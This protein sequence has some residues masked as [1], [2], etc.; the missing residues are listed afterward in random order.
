MKNISGVW[1]SVL[2]TAGL[3]HSPLA[4][5]VDMLFTGRLITAPRCT[6]TTEPI[7]VRY[8]L[9][10]VDKLA[11]PGKHYYEQEVIY[12]PQCV[13]LTYQDAYTV[14]LLM[15]GA[16]ASFDNRY[17]AT[18]VEGLAI[19]MQLSNNT[20]ISVNKA[21]TNKDPRNWP[22]LY[23]LLVKDPKAKLDTGTFK[24]SATMVIL[25]Q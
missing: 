13:N 10:D 15:V 1:G 5:A 19:Q 16:S 12:S 3:L 22:S 9:V 4:E 8:G 6:L 18:D 7:T 20:V 17:L 24:A 2:L 25:V 14:E 11:Q 21:W 23:A